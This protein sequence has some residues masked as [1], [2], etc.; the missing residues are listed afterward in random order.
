MLFQ[1]TDKV[2]ELGFTPVFVAGPG[3][4][5]TS[6]LH[7]TLCT[8]L[9]NNITNEY[10]GECTYFTHLLRTY[11]SVVNH[12]D[13]I[14]TSYFNSLDNFNLYH[15]N[16]IRSFL[17]DTWDYLGRP[18]NLV[19]KAPGLILN[20]DLLAQILPEA[21]FVVSV[22]DPLD[23]TASMKSVVSKYEKDIVFNAEYVIQLANGIKSNYLIV[24]NKMDLYK[25]RILFPKY[26]NLV[27][28]ELD[29]EIY[30]FLGIRVN[31]NNLWKS[32]K[33]NYQDKSGW[34]TKLYNAPSTD[35]SVG[36]YQSKLTDTEIQIVSSI[37][38]DVMKYF[39]YENPLLNKES[40]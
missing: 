4:S 35:S 39:G 34:L 16:L 17:V 29:E 18:K 38:A 22:R 12:Y 30:K 3:R 8:D 7:A 15:S 31:R 9:E 19:L 36:S 13:S 21:K 27:T 28:G 6:I 40:V 24:L 32:V 14:Y 25:G 11:Y 20:F 23:I 37:C 2:I 5:G 1:D 26:K 10:V 33:Y